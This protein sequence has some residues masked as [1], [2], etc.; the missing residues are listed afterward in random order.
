MDAGEYGELGRFS[1]FCWMEGKGVY[2]R[3]KIWKKEGYDRFQ[4]G[5]IEGQGID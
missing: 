5:R 2:S 1:M 4:V 3:E